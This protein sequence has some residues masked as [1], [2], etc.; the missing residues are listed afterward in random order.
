[1]NTPRIIG[2]TAIFCLFAT[3]G[4]VSAADYTI[5][6]KNQFDATLE[7]PS[8]KVEVMRLPLGPI[9]KDTSFTFSSLGRTTMTVSSPGCTSIRLSGQCIYRYPHGGG[10]PLT[11]SSDPLGPL[12]CENS[13]ATI[14]RGFPGSITV[15]P[16]VAG[17]NA[18]IL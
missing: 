16:S 13:T 15:T 2:A 10:H 11:F 3:A 4:M 6:W 5:T 7:C 8:L 1:M 9:Q 17:A 18:A 14:N 12:P